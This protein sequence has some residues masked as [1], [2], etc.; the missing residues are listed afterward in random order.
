M[1]R[2]IVHSVD[3]VQGAVDRWM[4]SLS[5]RPSDVSIPV[6]LS[7]IESYQVPY[8]LFTPTITVRCSG[9]YQINDSDQ[10]VSASTEVSF[11]ESFHEIIV[12]ASSQLNQTLMDEIFDTK[13]FHP[14][15]S[16]KR[17]SSSSSPPSIPSH[18][19]FQ[20]R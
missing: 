3:L 11:T 6:P 19:F 17:I 5:Y 1:S 7:H 12:M 20:K 9:T 8:Y 2:S 15:L 16:S 14:P 13:G 10:T 18:P 4:S